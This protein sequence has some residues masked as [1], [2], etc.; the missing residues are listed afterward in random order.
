MDGPVR[1]VPRP[2]AEHRQADRGAPERDGR[3]RRERVQ[4]GLRCGHRGRPREDPPGRD[5]GRQ[6]RVRR[7]DAVAA[8]PGG[9]PAGA[10]DPVAVRRDRRPHGPRVGAGERGRAVRRA[11]RGGG[12]HVP[13]AG[14]QVPRVPALHQ[15]ADELLER[16]GL[17]RDHRPRPG[18]A[19]APLHVARAV[20]GHDGLRRETAGGLPG[21]ARK[22]RR[23]REQRVPVGAVHQ[24]L[25]EVRRQGDPRGVRVLRRGRGQAVWART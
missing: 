18:M 3:G 24:G 25:S 14:G 2:P 7:G 16:P 11:G 5:Q 1:P 19:G 6:R 13:E 15:A 23:G 10:A 21:A 17:E 4:H 8:A 20:R 12:P 22:G 9:R